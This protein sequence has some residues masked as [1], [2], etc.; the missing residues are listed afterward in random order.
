MEQRWS[1]LTDKVNIGAQQAQLLEFITK[2]NMQDREQRNDPIL[3]QDSSNASFE[4]G[5]AWVRSK[6]ALNPGR[7][8]GY[9][10]YS[11]FDFLN[12]QTPLTKGIQDD[13]LLEED[14]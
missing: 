8:Y 10:G 3:R 7:K 14:M 5:V 12:D 1:Q 9:S 11:D 13:L 2:V 4:R 6:S